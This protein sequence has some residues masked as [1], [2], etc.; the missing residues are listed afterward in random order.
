MLK[1][2]ISGIILLISLNSSAQNPIKT[3]PDN[4]NFLG[5]RYDTSFENLITISNLTVE[6]FTTYA[7]QL[8]FDTKLTDNFCVLSYPQCRGQL[9]H[10]TKCNK[11]VKYWWMDYDSQVS[12]LMN[13]YNYLD[14]NAKSYYSSDFKCYSIQYENKKYVFKFKS[15][16]APNGINE[17]MIIDRE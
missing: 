3:V 17:M 13:I 10:M 7:K 6:E 4:T 1:Y 8:G 12:T 14:N 11:Q 16:T 5:K 2:L 9:Q 15:E